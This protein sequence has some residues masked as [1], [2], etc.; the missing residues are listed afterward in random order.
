MRSKTS[1]AVCLAA[2]VA[3]LALN[4]DC[5]AQTESTQP[6]QRFDANVPT[7]TSQQ[8]SDAS[9]M[10][11]LL[12]P[13]SSPMTTMRLRLEKNDPLFDAMPREQLV[14]LMHAYGAATAHAYRNGVA[15]DQ[16]DEA[17]MGFSALFADASAR[18]LEDIGSA[19]FPG[20]VEVLAAVL[21][22]RGWLG[23]D[24]RKSLQ[25]S[26]NVKPDGSQL[27]PEGEGG[28]FFDNTRPPVPPEKRAVFLTLLFEVNVAKEGLRYEGYPRSSDV[29]KALRVLS[30]RSPADAHYL[31]QRALR[32]FIS[33]KGTQ[34]LR[35]EC[36][37]AVRTYAPL[38]GSPTGR[39]TA[40]TALTR[41][42]DGLV[43]ANGGKWTEALQHLD[44]AERSF[45]EVEEGYPPVVRACLPLVRL[46]KSVALTL[47]GDAAQAAGLCR[48]EASSEDAPPVTRKAF[49][50]VGGIASSLQSTK[51]QLRGAGSS[52]NAPGAPDALSYGLQSPLSQWVD[53]TNFQQLNQSW[54]VA[55]MSP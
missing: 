45:Q 5:L 30:E 9:R 31:A 20:D 52:P 36:A 23:G 24:P 17:Y 19:R 50:M 37:Q 28:G 46:G 35:N 55:P 2:V 7:P 4:A 1:F 18:L 49:E 10:E 43:A 25:N 44:A 53:F 39:A 29:G 51:L 26:L 47:T 12:K 16:F 22:Y 38:D 21:W 34:R 27:A 40:Q 8:R 14:R 48:S 11:A 42:S 33:V 15:P 54:Y 32:Q 13:R 41:F 3:S 6:G